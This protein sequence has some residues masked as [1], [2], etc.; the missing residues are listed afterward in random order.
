MCVRVCELYY[1]QFYYYYFYSLIIV[2]FYSLGTRHCTVC[3][4]SNKECCVEECTN[5]CHSPERECFYCLHHRDPKTRCVKCL[6]KGRP[7]GSSLCSDCNLLCRTNDCK[8]QIANG[9]ETRLCS[10]CN[11]LCRKKGCEKAFVD[12]VTKLCSTCLVEAEAIAKEKRLERKARCRTKNLMKKKQ[13]EH[14]AR[15]LEKELER[16][17]PKKR[18]AAPKKKPAQTYK[19]IQQEIARH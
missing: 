1:R 13:L 7:D 16:V 11:L 3:S 19:Q 10:T 8:N 18:T 9:S 12:G 5:R 2:L 6:T 15:E 17:P 14:K 4:N